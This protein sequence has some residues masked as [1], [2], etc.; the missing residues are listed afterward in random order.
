MWLFNIFRN[1]KCEHKWKNIT[2]YCPNGEMDWYYKCV[3]CG[4]EKNK[5][6]YINAQVHE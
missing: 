6:S 2:Y 4:K 5:P 3:K 1:K